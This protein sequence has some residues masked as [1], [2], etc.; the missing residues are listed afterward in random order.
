MFPIHNLHSLM[1]KAFQIL[2]LCGLSFSLSNLPDLHHL[3]HHLPTDRAVMVL[4]LPRAL[5][6][7]RQMPTGQ[8]DGIDL[9]FPADM[10]EEVFLIRMLELHRSL[11]ETFPLFEFASVNIAMF[12]VFHPTLTIGLVGRPFA[13]VAIAIGIIHGALTTFLARD[14]I[15]IISIPRRSNPDSVAVGSAAFEGMCSVASSEIGAV[16]FLPEV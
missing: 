9:A 11:A 14:E 13:L 15:A 16:R 4:H 7:R 3:L 10:A 1:P 2:M 5:L 6:T 8:E 12:D